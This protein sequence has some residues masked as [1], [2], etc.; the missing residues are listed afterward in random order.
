MESEPAEFEL[1]PGELVQRIWRRVSAAL[2]EAASAS[3]E[4]SYLADAP[5]A[6]LAELQRFY[7]LMSDYP[8]RGGKYLRGQVV[9]LSSS[10]HGAETDDAA[11][12][13]AAAIELFQAWVLIHDDIEDD[14]ETRRGSPALHRTV[15]MPVA[16][17]VGDALHVRM[18]R[19]L[20][21]LLGST[22]AAAR[23]VIEEFA[24]MIER[25]AEGQHLDLAYVQEGRVAV[26]EGEYLDLVSRKTAG[27]TVVSP[28]RLGA[29]LAGREPSSLLADA[30]LELG[31]AFQ[32]RDDVLNLQRRPHH[33]DSYGKEFA[34]D[35]Y[36][37]KRTLILAHLFAA[38]PPTDAAVAREILVRSRS[39]R[40]QGDVEE[41]LG[42]IERH[43]SLT[44]A[45]QVA[46]EKA[47]RGMAILREALADLPRRAA[48]G[49]LLELLAGVAERRA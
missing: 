39:E 34:G 35:L 24:T 17:N 49:R 21:G 42:L 5:S 44:Y 22:P 38:A 3:R 40:T 13:V 48:A 12:R 23:V 11:L 1:A 32:I 9:Y 36:E 6:N 10:A 29:L 46:D 8:G 43:G 31:V 30:G 27:Y 4:A 33:S 14:S 15:G 20:H 41:L 7:D 45:Q 16:L 26:S 47:R 25:T 28:L 19:V 18:W 37:G 2:A